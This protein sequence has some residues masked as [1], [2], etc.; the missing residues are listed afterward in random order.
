MQRKDRRR[1]LN[2]RIRKGEE[3]ELT[4][5]GRDGGCPPLLCLT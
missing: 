1:Y 3:N 2:K 4:W 5:K